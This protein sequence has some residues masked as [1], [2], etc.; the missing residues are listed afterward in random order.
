VHLFGFITIIYRGQLNVKLYWSFNKGAHMQGHD[1]LLFT[2]L[3]I[4]LVCTLKCCANNANR[5]HS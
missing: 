4:I 1:F 2:V 3:L 5:K